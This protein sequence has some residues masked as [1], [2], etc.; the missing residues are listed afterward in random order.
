MFA[1]LFSHFL[2]CSQN[3]FAG[4]THAVAAS[5]C[6][7][8]ALSTANTALAQ[9]GLS[10][11]CIVEPEMTI[12]LSSAIDGVAREITVDKSARI[13]KGQT[14]VMLESGIEQSKVA[15]ARKRSEMNEDIEAA[16]IE[17]HLARRKRDRIIE[18]FN[19]K[20]VP[21]FEKDEAVTNT[22]L[23][24]VELK[25][26]RHQHELAMLELERAEADLALRTLTSP[27]DGIVVERFINPGESVK[28]KPLLKLAQVDPMRVEIIAD[29]SLF[30]LIKEGTEAEIIIEGPKESEHSAAVTL[31][32]G[33]VDAASGTFG[34]RLQL[35]NPEGNVVG[36]LKCKAIFNIKPPPGVYLGGF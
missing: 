14:L 28:D 11:D 23:A 31:V 33:L 24:H 25:K 10:L 34:I 8:L 3:A 17:Y 5:L 26:A 4:K 2:S 19:K 18:L 1:R 29:S 20:S 35:P 6:C 7:A 9:E 15:L 12:E 30:G 22:S 16:R 21:S 32:D 36:G 27:I 13:E